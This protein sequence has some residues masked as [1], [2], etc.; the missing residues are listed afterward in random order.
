MV[1]DHAITTAEKGE[2]YKMSYAEPV[3]HAERPVGTPRENCS[4]RR[5][6]EENL[7]SIRRKH[8]ASG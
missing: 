3:Y 6:R 8:L 1:E 2:V 7:S 4:L 5:S